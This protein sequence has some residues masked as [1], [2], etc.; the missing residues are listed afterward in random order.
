MHTPFKVF[1][2]EQADTKID[3]LLELLDLKRCKMI[4]GFETSE[5]AIDFNK[6]EEILK[7]KRS[8][9][10]EYIKEALEINE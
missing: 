8:D 9:S 3:E 1:S 4:T 10:L 5:A 6:V 2:R 7:A